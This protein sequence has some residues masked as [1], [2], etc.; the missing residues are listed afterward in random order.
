MFNLLIISLCFLIIFIIFGVDKNDISNLKDDQLIKK[1]IDISFIGQKQQLKQINKNYTFLNYCIHSGLLV[2]AVIILIYKPLDNLLYT[3]ILSSII[4]FVYPFFYRIRVYSMHQKNVINNVFIYTQY[5]LV[6]IMEDMVLDQVLMLSSK[7]LSEKMNKELM[8]VR[9]FI[10]KTNDTKRGLELF[11]AIYPYSIVKMVHILLIGKKQDGAISE[12][13]ISYIKDSIDDFE[14]EVTNFYEKKKANK[15]IFYII[16]FLN[17]V[18]VYMILD[19]FKVVAKSEI[20]SIILFV[21]YLLNII[22]LLLYEKWCFN[23]KHID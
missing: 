4:I 13:L 17:L 3:I 23:Q 6:Y 7:A 20:L 8:I 12:E 1:L 10:H 14:I 21:F 5:V 16:S 2:L 9:D 11:E 22:T 18:S 19:L 15:K